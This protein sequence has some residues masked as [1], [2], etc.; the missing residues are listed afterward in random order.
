MTSAQMYWYNWMMRASARGFRPVAGNARVNPWK[1]T[2]VRDCPDEL[3]A[4]LNRNDVPFLNFLRSSHAPSPW[5]GFYRMDRITIGDMYYDL[6]LEYGMGD[7]GSIMLTFDGIPV[8]SKTPTL[9]PVAVATRK[10]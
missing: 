10:F 6:Q 9:I 5:K 3:I 7:E 8:G 1:W 2:P 4:V